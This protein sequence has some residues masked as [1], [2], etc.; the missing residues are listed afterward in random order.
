MRL[1]GLLLTAALLGLPLAARAQ[2]L[3]ALRAQGL[4]C[5]R[6]GPGSA[7]KPFLDTSHRL[8]KQAEA[9]KQ[10]RC[11]TALLGFEARVMS[12]PPEA[13]ADPTALDPA[14]GELSAECES[15]R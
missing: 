12:L 4:A 13:S 15:N 9:A 5:V 6:G 1:L 3:M 11:Y 14:S 2:G 10:L 8:K 7:C